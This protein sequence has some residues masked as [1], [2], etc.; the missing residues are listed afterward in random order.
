MKLLNLVHI[1]SFADIDSWIVN[2]SL[3]VSVSSLLYNFFPFKLHIFNAK[4][5]IPYFLDLPSPFSFSTKFRILSLSAQ[6]VLTEKG[7]RIIQR[8]QKIQL[9]KISTEFKD[10]KFEV[11]NNT[12]NPYSKWV[13]KKRLK[14]WW[15]GCFFFFFQYISDDDASSLAF[16]ECIYQECLV[17]CDR[18]P[19]IKFF[20]QKGE[21]TYSFNKEVMEWNSYLIWLHQGLKK[22]HWDS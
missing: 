3:H 22:Q 9:I 12:E 4:N 21:I 15:E 2:I 1:S 5:Y 11:Q 16:L 20:S 17:A 7:L 8:S 6:S 19:T 10:R 18:N 14:L 13:Q